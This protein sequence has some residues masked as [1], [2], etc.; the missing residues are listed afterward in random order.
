MK[1]KHVEKELK[2][3][4]SC[5]YYNGGKKDLT[6]FCDKLEHFVSYKGYCSRHEEGDKN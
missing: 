1:N 6:A 3:C 2:F 5:K 4:E